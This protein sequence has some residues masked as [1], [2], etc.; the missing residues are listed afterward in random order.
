MHNCCIKGSSFK[1]DTPPNSL[2]DSNASPKMKIVEE[3]G[4]GVHSLTHS[5]LGVRRACWSY[6]MGIRMSDN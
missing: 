2:K 5:T 3:K 4:V 1:I 6:G